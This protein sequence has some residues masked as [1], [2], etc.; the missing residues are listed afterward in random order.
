M[1]KMSQGSDGSL[2]S[3]L[4]AMA[5]CLLYLLACFLP[6]VDC[7]PTIPIGEDQFPDI[8]KGQIAGLGILLFGWGGGNNG[9]PWSANVFFAFG[10]ACLWSKWFHA[11]LW[12]GI[13]ATLLG[14]TTWW[15]R[16]YDTLMIGYYLWQASLL[17]LAVGAAFAIRQSARKPVPTPLTGAQKQDLLR[18]LTDYE[19]DRRTGS[20][21]EEVEARLQERE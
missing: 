10:I 12:S 20:T 21:W 3:F 4:T 15:V 11:A 1:A 7:G 13:L 14:L 19:A 2:V 16:R 8:D 6:C 5:V 9:V 18:R 17:A